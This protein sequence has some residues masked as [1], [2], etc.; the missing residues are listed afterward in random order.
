MNFSRF[1]IAVLALFI[2]LCLG[3]IYNSTFTAVE[4][5]ALKRAAML[6]E[7]KADHEAKRY[8]IVTTEKE[9]KHA[10]FPYSTKNDREGMLYFLTGDIEVY[11]ANNTL[12]SVTLE[13]SNEKSTAVA[14][15]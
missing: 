14:D 4:Q 5:N 6:R 7:R 15:R 11:V 1:V 10:M 12:V 13:S 8:T 2:I 3:F 9:Y